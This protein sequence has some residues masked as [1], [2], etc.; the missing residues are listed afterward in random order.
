MLTCNS[1]CSARAVHLNEHALFCR[2]FFKRTV[3]L[4]VS[5]S[6][7]NGSSGFCLNKLLGKS[8]KEYVALRAVGIA[9][10]GSSH[11]QQVKAPSRESSAV[12][13]RIMHQ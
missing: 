1:S 3:V 6:A 10:A 7:S 4:L 13:K 11:P 2:S 8:V 5:S 9:P 12:N